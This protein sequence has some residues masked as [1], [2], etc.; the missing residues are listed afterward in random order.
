MYKLSALCI[1]MFCIAT[2]TLSQNISV[3]GILNDTIEKKPVKNAV[4]ALLTPK[5]SILYRFT[6]TAADGSFSLKN[7]KPGNYIFTTVHPFYADFIDDVELKD[8]ETNLGSVAVTSKSKLLQEV[9]VKSGNPIHIKGDTTI[10]TADSFKV[11]ANANVEELLKKLPGIQIDK[12]GKIKAMGET[13]EKVLVDGEEFFGDDPGMAIKNLRADAVKEV[14]VFD[15]KSDQAEFTGIDDGKTKKTINLKLKD[16]R[17][18]GYFGKIELTGGLQNKIDNRYNNNILLNAFKGKRKIAGYLLQGNTGQDGLGWRDRQKFGGDDD[19]VVMN[20]DEDDGAMMIMSSRGGDEDP[21]INTENGFFENLNIGLQYSNK[22]KDKQTLNYSPKFNKL[23]YNNTKNTFSQFQLS[24]KL[25]NTNAVE[26][27]F[28]NKQNVKN[29]FSYDFKIDS[30]NSLKITGKL[31]IY[32]T[33]SSVYKSSENLDENNLFN[34]S[35]KTLTDNN[36]D[37]TSFTTSVL[38]KHKF[39]KER[40]T[41]SINTDFSSVNSDGIA[42]LNALNK[43]YNNGVLSKIDSIDQKKNMDNTSK[44]IVAHAAY[45]EPLSKKYSLELNYELSWTAGK[46]NLTTLSKNFASNGKYEVLVDSLSNNFN[47]DIITNKTGFRISYKNKKVKYGFGTAVGFTKFDLKDITINKDYLRNYTNIFPA[48]NFQYTYKPNH[49]LSIN[50]K[51]N[52]AQPSISQLQ[53]LRNN[54]DPLNIYLGNP[55]LKQSFKNG[56]DINHNSYNFVKEIWTYQSINFSSTSNAFTT[57][58]TIDN[59][60]KITTQPINTNGNFNA[61][62][63]MGSGIKLKKLNANLNL[64]AG[65]SF[66]KFNDIV[67][68]QKNNNENANASIS[69]VISK[70]KD[71]KYEFNLNNDFGYNTNK[72]TISNRLIKYNTNTISLNATIYYKKV[73]KLNSEFT[74]N[75]RQKTSDFAKNVNNS[76]WNA[77][78]ERTF[79]NDE[80]TVFALIRDILNQ[81]IGIDRSIYGNTLTEERNDRLQRYWMIGVIWDFKNKS[82]K[83]K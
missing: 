32:N 31:N 52:T 73:W 71:K 16:D 70:V 42:Y 20:F 65:F 83:T 55:L 28:V 23:K 22:W 77:R 69:A 21:Y 63:W 74:N 61:G 13:V 76:L 39:K 43:L 47:Q 6:R 45:T 15:K 9:I 59:S 41:F 8:V 26:N 18:K 81:N 53:N 17:K 72:S 27:T 19:N 67:N 58:T 1:A 44:K 64:N 14:Q 57:N 37:K 50:Y 49:S 82:A 25:F 30:V 12:D 75:Y 56:I 35:S 78:M 4:I 60:G 48:A 54:A 36:T 29:N 46:N 11:S 79:K 3:S 62:G 66:S 10:Y 40:R 33:K 2:I 51:G 7:I 38:F 68:N 80:F 34:N 5:D 24:N